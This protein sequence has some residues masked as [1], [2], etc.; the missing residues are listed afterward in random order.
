MQ[1]AQQILELAGLE[2]ANLLIASSK[3]FYDNNWMYTKWCTQKF[4]MLLLQV[5]QYTQSE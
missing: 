4:K 1:Y 5:D 2:F 3:W